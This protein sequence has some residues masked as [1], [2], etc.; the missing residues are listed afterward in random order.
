MVRRHR[1][2]RV[3][4]VAAAPFGSAPGEGVEDPLGL[5]AAYPAGLAI[6]RSGTVVVGLAG[7][8][9]RHPHRRRDPLGNPSALRAPRG[10]LGRGPVPDEQ[11]VA[12]AHSEHGDSRHPDLR[13]LSLADGSTVAELS[14][15]PG[16]GVSRSGSRPSAVTRGCSSSTNAPAVPNSSSWTCR[17]GGRC[18]SRWGS[19][20]GRRGGVDAGRD[21]SRRAARPRGPHPGLPP[22]PRDRCRHA[23]RS[24]DGQRRRRHGPPR[25]RR[26]AH[27]VLRGAA[28]DGPPPRRFRPAARPRRT[29]PRRRSRCRTC[30]S[31]GPAAAST[32][33]CAV[34]RGPRARCRRSWRCT[35]GRRPTTP[36]RS[37]RTARRG[38]TRVSPSCR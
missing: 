10:R 5:P 4:R 21:R 16:K 33:C 22:R 36:T 35:A 20:R 7:R 23:G 29:P 38:W 3:R 25:R 17:R 19:R 13:V 24:R 32:R 28:L 31:T 15:G 30:G 18:R 14:D 6:G 34:P 37:G 27:V 26:V 11:W 1:G 12:I 2:R 8:R 9:V